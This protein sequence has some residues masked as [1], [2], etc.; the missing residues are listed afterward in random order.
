MTRVQSEVAKAAGLPVD[1]VTV[2]NH[3][4]GGGFGRKL[5]PDMVIS[6]RAHRQ[7]RGRTGQGGLDPRG[8]HPP[9][10]LPAGLSRHHRGDGS[11]RQDRRLE[12]PGHR[13]VGHGALAAAGVSR[14]A[15]TSTPSIAPVDMPYDIPNFH[16]E[17]VRAEPPAVSSPASG[18]AS[19]LTTTCS[20]SRA[21]STSWRSKAG[22]DP[23]EFRRAHARQD[24]HACSRRSTRG[25]KSGWGQP[26]PAR[27]GRGVCRAALV[28]QLHRHRGRG[29][30][31]RKRRGAR[32]AASHPP[33]TPG[34]PSIRTRSS[35]NSRAD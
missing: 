12:A 25:E 24:T 31:G 5:E 9:R 2:H 16:V 21:S 6:R 30:S 7:A 19:A 1:K 26:L 22:K 17:Y 28:R 29:R 20:P 33:S 27:V 10:C 8:R 23:V 14:T 3:L 13:L 32:C 4:L 11:R 34:S 35:R 15:S 18:A